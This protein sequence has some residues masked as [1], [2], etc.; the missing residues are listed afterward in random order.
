MWYGFIL[1]LLY[2][3]SVVILL[4]PIKFWQYFNLQNYARQLVAPSL[5]LSLISLGPVLILILTEEQVVDLRFFFG[6]LGLS[7]FSLMIIRLLTPL[8]LKTGRL[9]YVLIS[10]LHAVTASFM[11]YFMIV[12]KPV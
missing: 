4:I 10:C 8:S 9:I 7:I 6:L 1:S 5:L 12:Y 3:I 11:T 2:F